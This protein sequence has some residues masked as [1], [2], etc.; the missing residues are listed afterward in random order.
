VAFKDDAGAHDL[1]GRDQELAVLA[2]FIEAVRSG[3]ARTLIVSGD[4]GVGKTALV[5][6]ACAAAG[7]D[8]VIVKGA[9]LPLAGQ[10]VPYLG[11]RAALRSAPAALAAPLFSSATHVPLPDAALRIDEWISAV[12]DEQP[13]LLVIDDLQ[14]VDQDSLDVLMYLAAGPPNRRFGL[15]C[16]LRTGQLGEAHG[17]HTWLAD[18]RRLPG[19]R[20][21]T[22]PAL[23]RPGTEAQ[24]GQLLGSPPGQSLVTEIF[25]HSGGNPYFNLLL[26]EGLATGSAQLP[27]GFPVDLR[28]AVLRSWRGLP[29]EVRN[30]TRI[31][32]VGGR[33]ISGGDLESIAAMDS[34]QGV[35]PQLLRTAT[36]AGILDL[37]PDGTYWF[38]HP[39]I[40]EVLEQGLSADERKRWH[41]AFC[42]L[43]ENQFRDHPGGDRLT[44]LADH[45]YL[46]G[47][48]DEA[49][50]WAVAAADAAARSG[51]S[52]DALRMLQRAVSLWKQA[53]SPNIR[54]RELWDRVRTEAFAAGAFAAE[55]EA[56]EELLASLDTVRE[57]LAAAELRV[58]RM[59]LRWSLGHAFFTAEDV[60][61]AVRLSAVQPGSWQHAFALAELAHSSQWHVRS[62][63]DTVAVQALKLARA[64]G[65]PRAMA[66]ALT[67]SAMAAVFG[68]RP[69]EAVRL[70]YEAAA[71]AL[72][73]RDFWAYVHAYAWVGNA[74]ETWASARYADLMRAGRRELAAHGAP[75]AYMSK[76]AAD[77]AASYL[78]AGDWQRTQEAL[79]TV[80]SFDPGPM[81]DVSGRLTAARLAALQG[82]VLE[83]R[84]QLA[85]AEEVNQDTA[86]FVNLNVAAVRAEVEAAGGYP[87]KS[88]EAAMAGATRPGP[89]PTMCEWLVPLA[90]RALADR[91]GQA[92]DSG[93]PTAGLV[94]ASRRLKEEFPEVL[95]EPGVQSTLYRSQLVA[96]SLLYTAELGRA[97]FSPANGEQ[98][99]AAAEAFRIGALPWEEVYCCRRAAEVL[100]TG[101]EA[102]RSLAAG[103]LRHGLSLAIALNAIPH[104]DALERLAVHARVPVV[105]VGSGNGERGGLPG[106]TPR[107]SAVL[108]HV[109][110]GRTYREI[111]EA[112]VISEKTVSSHISSLLRKTGAANRVDL[113]RLAAAKAVT[114]S[115]G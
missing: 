99:A 41:A 34:L 108:N 68:E 61:E 90:A 94:A 104:R 10:E 72:A 87:E 76:L 48:V 109:M 114:R 7:T 103:L 92:R 111:A 60:N 52:G 15:V 39:L 38:H 29:E 59:H 18:L 88:F 64:S 45:Y 83:A 6:Q 74:Q 1:V 71:D 56:V 3:T 63:D 13:V 95:R 105:P 42:V 70:A 16:T 69:D 9:A 54:L 58:R 2:A 102:H 106:L 107:E 21:C 77:E 31:L 14:W 67:S 47:N 25:R 11:L 44:A 17:L 113:A 8:V 43:Y 19:V 26:S 79:R 110:A 12:A 35:V 33:A 115:S 66:Y 32:A 5:E 65:H 36:E 89:P 55:L 93:S 30:L 51:A 62:G 84:A 101:G 53:R 57:P 91:A 28:Q 86:A 81:G 20:L 80:R 112:L 75:H 98:W 40:A 22:L 49:F 78:A 50:R 97:D 46:A 96:F 4:A 73:A 24:L 27:P 85:R 37:E 100:L 82:R 23:D